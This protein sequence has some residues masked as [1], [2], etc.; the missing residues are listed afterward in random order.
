MKNL[1]KHFCLIFCVII[2]SCDDK[3]ASLQELNSSPQIEY[4]S[5]DIT[6]WQVVSGV[7]IE[8]EAKVWT[9]DNNLN[10][11]AV[12][13]AT[14][15]N[16]NF[17][18]ISVF[19]LS[20]GLNFFINDTPYINSATVDLSTFSLAVRNE[21]PTTKLFEIMVRDTWGA[22]DFVQFEVTFKENLNPIADLNI[23]LVADIAENEYLLDASGSF[24]ADDN[25]GG[26][27]VEYEYIIDG[28]VVTIPINQIFHVFT[29]GPH[30]IQLR[31]KDND[32]EW[33][34]QITTTIIIP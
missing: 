7:T 23:E 3:E 14:D 19:S 5:S 15:F 28:V 4:F 9:P 16:S 8:T 12:L 34:D 17:G 31:C 33:S 20:G 22:E 1:Y 13:R 30:T 27:I 10:Y 29:P 18:E 6:E 21:V 32:N 11:S 26:F 25:I 2:F 24:D